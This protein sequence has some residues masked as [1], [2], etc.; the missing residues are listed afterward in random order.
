MKLKQN[1][2]LP[3]NAIFDYLGA[4]VSPFCHFAP[5]R[6]RFR[7]SMK[8][9]AFYLIVLVVVFLNAICVAIEHFGQ[10]AWLSDF[11]RRSRF[12]PRFECS[13]NAKGCLLDCL[14]VGDA[15][16]DLLQWIWLW[17]PPI[18]V[19]H[20]RLSDVVN[21]FLFAIMTKKCPSCL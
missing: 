20:F 3:V 18:N 15:L 8:S 11:L 12:F 5:Q 9:Q 16:S 19:S 1:E 10:P 14:E 21:S 13:Q 6:C 4:V 2:K 7:L 17:Q